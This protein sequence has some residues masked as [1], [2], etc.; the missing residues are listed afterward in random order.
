MGSAV[1]LAAMIIV[2]SVFLPDV[3]H[4]IE[5]FLLVLFGRATAVLNTIQPTSEIRLQPPQ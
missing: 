2:M 1:G 3:L 4:A 5:E